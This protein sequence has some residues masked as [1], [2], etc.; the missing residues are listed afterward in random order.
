[1]AI[2]LAAED[3]ESGGAR[4]AARNLLIAALSSGAVPRFA[5]ASGQRA[6][7]GRGD[8]AGELAALGEWL[9]D[10]L[11]VAAGADDEVADPAARQLLRRAVSR[12]SIHPLGAAAGLERVAQAQIW[13]Q[14]NVNPQLILTELLRGLQA[15]LL[16][17]SEEG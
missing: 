8:F 11:A 5:A 6:F 14:G 17:T 1:A 2:R 9:R 13:A 3:G 12:K 4:E 15:D 16:A 10:L 7:G